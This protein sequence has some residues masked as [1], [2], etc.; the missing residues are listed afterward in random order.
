M[1]GFINPPVAEIDAL[2]ASLQRVAVVGLS[3]N[4][5]RPSHGVGIAL[6]QQGLEVFPVRPAVATILGVRAYATLKELPQPVDLV[7]VF[8]APVHVD[9]IVE[10][11][12]ELG[13]PAIW[14]QEGVINQPA[15]QRAQAAGM[16]VVMD[17]CLWQEYHR[18]Q[19]R[20]QAVK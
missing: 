13:M 7:N 12:I 19:L 1:T 4:P 20:Q 11:A 16:M 5:A 6:Q 15:A 18:W 3:P 14:L 9:A 8:R 2:L 10:Q 17:L